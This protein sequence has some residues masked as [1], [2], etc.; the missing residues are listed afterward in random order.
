MITRFSDFFDKDVF[1]KVLKR[2]GER[3][4]NSAFAELSTPSR[5]R[6][7]AQVR[8]NDYFKFGTIS[9]DRN[10]KTDESTLNDAFNSTNL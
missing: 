7:L 1:L 9:W 8:S 5:S 6:S 10:D 2:K 4:H 3:G